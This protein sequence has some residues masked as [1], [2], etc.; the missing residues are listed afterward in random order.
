MHKLWKTVA[1]M[2]Y[3]TVSLLDLPNEI[4]LIILKKLNWPHILNS[5]VNVDE[6]LDRLIIDCVIHAS[7]IDLILKL[8]TGNFVSIAEPALNRICSHVLS[9]I[10]Q[11][12]K[13]L[14]LESSSMERILR[15]A[16]Y[17]K[18]TYLGLFECGPETITHHLT[19]M[20]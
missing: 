10:H 5:L 7:Y 15:A 20:E 4:L 9:Q 17:P 11:H 18:L 14:A 8:W 1:N 2:A 6:R 19:S 3:S 13:C 12:I 16:D